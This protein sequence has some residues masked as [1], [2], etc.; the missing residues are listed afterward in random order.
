MHNAKLFHLTLFA[1][2]TL[3]YQRY[4]LLTFISNQ[5]KRFFLI[6]MYWDDGWCAK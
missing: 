1:L 6:Y 5:G 3:A 2:S 4:S